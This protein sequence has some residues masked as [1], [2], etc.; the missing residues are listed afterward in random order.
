M[1]TAVTEGIRVTVESIYLAD[2]S[3]PEEGTYAFGYQVTIVNE[4][5]ENVRLMRRHWIITDGNGRVEE[6]EGPGVVGQQPTLAPGE[7]HRY[8]S[9]TVL[10][11][12]VGTMEG[13]YEMVADGGRV[14]KA[15]IP[16]FGLRVPGILH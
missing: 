3:T 15:G 1:P 10:A 5:D 16:R 11:T 13:T 9:G 8:S 7:E 6:V 2:R 4:G 14:F 12:P